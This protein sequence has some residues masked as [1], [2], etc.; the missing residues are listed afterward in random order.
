MKTSATAQ[1]NIVLAIGYLHQNFQN[2]LLPCPALPPAP[3]TLTPT[4]GTPMRVAGER[5]I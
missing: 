1:G 3:P 4:P 2:Q 5:D